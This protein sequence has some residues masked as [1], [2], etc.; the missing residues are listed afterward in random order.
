M[1]ACLDLF[2]SSV[3]EEQNSKSILQQEVHF[4]K[5]DKNIETSGSEVDIIVLVSGME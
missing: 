2:C 5:S 4:S 3:I 1:N